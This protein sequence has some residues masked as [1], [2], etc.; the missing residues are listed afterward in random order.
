MKNLADEFPLNRDKRT[1]N[2]KQ[3]HKIMNK[4]EIKKVSSLLR[5]YTQKEAVYAT[6]ENGFEPSVED[7][8]AAGIADPRRVVNQLRADH[9]FAIYLNDRKDRRGNVTRRYRLGTA[10]RNG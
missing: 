4:K 5:S 9:G 10:R 3:K 7:L 6:L 2:T 1:H 8:K